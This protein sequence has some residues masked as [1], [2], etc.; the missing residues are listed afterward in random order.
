VDV[1]D[2]RIRTA[3]ALSAL[4]ACLPMLQ[5]GPVTSAQLPTVRE[6]SAPPAGWSHEPRNA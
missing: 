5:T 4:L 1:K 2:K 6:A 3:I